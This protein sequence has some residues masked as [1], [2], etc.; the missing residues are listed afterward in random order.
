MLKD[1]VRDSGGPVQ[2]VDDAERRLAVRE[3]QRRLRTEPRAG[4]GLRPDAGRLRELDDANARHDQYASPFGSSRTANLSTRAIVEVDRENEPVPG[5][6]EP[7][8]HGFVVDR[9]QR[10]DEEGADTI[11][12]VLERL[13]R[14]NVGGGV[15]HGGAGPLAIARPPIVDVLRSFFPG[16]QRPP[17]RRRRLSVDQDSRERVTIPATTSSPIWT[18]SEFGA[19]FRTINVLRSARSAGSGRTAATLKYT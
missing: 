9:I 3:Q 1:A 16:D 10:P 4:D 7:R 2:P 5:V 12:R 11:R 14:R 8:E 6:D 17:E 13:E 18:A 19:V 15:Q